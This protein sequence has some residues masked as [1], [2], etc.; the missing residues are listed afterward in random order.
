ML[1]PVVIPLVIAALA[2]LAALGY[3]RWL[4]TPA[5]WNPVAR[6]IPAPYCGRHRLADATELFRDWATIAAERMYETHRREFAQQAAPDADPALFE[7]ELAGHD[8]H[9]MPADDDTRE[10]AVTR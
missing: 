1:I 8:D 7:L 5:T 9:S 6:L 3:R 4:D 2:I 10:L